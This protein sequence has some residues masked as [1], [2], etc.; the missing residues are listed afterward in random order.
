MEKYQ[1]DLQSFN[2]VPARSNEIFKKISLTI[3]AT[4][5]AT[6]TSEA[7]WKRFDKNHLD[8][9]KF[10][11]IPNQIQLPDRQLADSSKDVG[12]MIAV[13]KII[14]VSPTDWARIGLKARLTKTGT[15]RIIP[16]PLVWTSIVFDILL[17]NFNFLCAFPMTYGSTKNLCSGSC[18]ECG[19]EFK[20]ENMEDKIWEE[21][22]GA[23]FKIWFS[24][25]EKIKQHVKKRQIKGTENRTKVAKEIKESAGS[26]CSL[27]VMN[28]EAKK[29]TSFGKK[30]IF[31]YN[32]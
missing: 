21:N 30:L 9:Q 19:A 12:T 29:K 26:S 28:E 3:S 17:A 2:E 15:K 16:E 5:K 32:L 27:F 8:V 11:N 6:V 4:C 18:S 20:C 13:E 10:L 1:E 24:H 7:V 14:S 22:E 31:V 23:T 25:P